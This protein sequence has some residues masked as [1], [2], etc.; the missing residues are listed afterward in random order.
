MSETR[1]EEIRRVAKRE[2]QNMSI[3]DTPSNYLMFLQGIQ[4]AWDE[5]QDKSFEKRL[6]QVALS[7]E[8]FLAKIKVD[9]PKAFV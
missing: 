4:E 1:N 2:M 7:A 8:I 3:E 9:F 6:Y 5:D